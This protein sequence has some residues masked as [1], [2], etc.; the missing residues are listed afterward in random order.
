M[1]QMSPATA[2]ATVEVK[3]GKVDANIALQEAIAN[4]GQQAKA[5]G[6][7]LT[8]FRAFKPRQALMGFER[9]LS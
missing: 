3:N 2:E 6:R 5:P 7:H 1:L 9:E 4:F 8:Y